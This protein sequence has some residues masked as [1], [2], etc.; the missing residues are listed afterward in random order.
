MAHNLTPVET[1]LL[2]ITYN[3]RILIKYSNNYSPSPFVLLFQKAENVSIQWVMSIQRVICQYIF[4]LRRFMENSRYCYLNLL[5]LSE[6][7]SLGPICQQKAYLRRF[8]KKSSVCFNFHFINNEKVANLKLQKK[9]HKEMRPR[10]KRVML[11]LQEK[12]TL[13]FDCIKYNYDLIKC[14]Q[15]R[16]KPGNRSTY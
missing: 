10:E 16:K 9:T 1:E 3:L 7:T 15:F 11:T 6:I 14:S 12:N 4:P 5:F 2:V 8:R 13:I